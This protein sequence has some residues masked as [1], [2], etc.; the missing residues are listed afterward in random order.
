MPSK[1]R[2]FPRLSN[3]IPAE[4][5]FSFLSIRH[6]GQP[7]LA[8]IRQRSREYQQRPQCSMRSRHTTQ[9]RIASTALHGRAHPPLG[10]DSDSEYISVPPPAPLPLPQSSIAVG[11]GAEVA[12]LLQTVHVRTLSDVALALCCWCL[13]L[14]YHPSCFRPLLLRA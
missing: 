7:S 4:Y 5:R 13:A 14:C 2:S 12:K 8:R 10:E 6:R 3:Q 9:P 1:A 11:G